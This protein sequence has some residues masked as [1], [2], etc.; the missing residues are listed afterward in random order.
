MARQRGAVNYKNKILIDIV[1]KMLPNGSYGWNGVAL[2]YHE[3]S[4][5]EA[6]RDGSDVKNHWVKK[7]CNSMKKPTGKT[8]EPGDRIIR[9]I[10]IERRIMDRTHSGLLGLSDDWVDEY[11]DENTAEGVGDGASPSAMVPAL[12]AVPPL[13][14]S[15]RRTSTHRDEEELSPGEEEQTGELN[16]DNGLTPPPPLQQVHTASTSAA[17]TAAIRRLSTSTTQS[18]KTKNSTNKR[19]KERTSIAGAIVKLIEKQGNG[20]GDVA[21]NMSMMMMRQLEQMN[22]SMDKRDRREEKERRKKRKRKRKKRKRKKAR[23]GSSVSSSSSS[24][25]SS[26]DE[27]DS[28]SSA[29]NSKRG[30]TT[31]NNDGTNDKD[32]G[33]GKMTADEKEQYEEV[34]REEAAAE[35][36]HRQYV[37]SLRE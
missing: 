3:A 32:D 18:Q 23:K 6:L 24:S 9:C 27:S 2:A 28:D 34:L 29:G 10:E 22:K 19:P 4:Q 15:P 12:L 33:F 11:E 8:G 21:M 20:S 16:M 30:T 36:Y 1:E 35:E 25:S 31:S 37:D 17:S 26:S 7:L 14:R 5:E 13:R